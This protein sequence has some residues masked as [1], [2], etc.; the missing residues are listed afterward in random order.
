MFA[1]I[2]GGALAVVFVG[3]PLAI[4]GLFIQSFFERGGAGPAVNGSGSQPIDSEHFGAHAGT[5]L[6]AVSSHRPNT[7]GGLV[8]PIVARHNEAAAS[9]RAQDNGA[10]EGHGTIS[11][12]RSMVAAASF[13]PDYFRADMRQRSQRITSSAQ[14]RVAGCL[15]RLRPVSAH[16]VMRRP[17]GAAAAALPVRAHRRSRLRHA[18]R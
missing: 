1:T 7:L 11:D 6:K 5:E 18:V 16:A 3:L 4:I 9:V 12:P 14:R 15:V 8:A 13:P 2:V 10:T 17:I